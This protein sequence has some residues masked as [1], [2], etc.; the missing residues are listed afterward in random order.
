MQIHPNT[1]ADAG[2]LHPSL[3]RA[4]DGLPHLWHEERLIFQKKQLK[5]SLI[6]AH[7][8]CPLCFCPSEMSSCSENSAVFLHRVYIWLPLWVIQL[9]VTFQQAVLNE[10]GFRG[11]PELV[12]LYWW[13]CHDGFL[14][15][16]LWGIK[17][18]AR[19]TWLSFLGLYTLWSFSTYRTKYSETI[20]GV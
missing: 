10:K 12:Q 9:Q 13:W 1:I 2:F 16:A 6:W 20:Q 4:P 19:P 18:P 17:G 7:A 8:M 3:I 5:Y 14:C 11:T 15:S